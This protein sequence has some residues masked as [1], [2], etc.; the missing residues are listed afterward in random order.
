MIRKNNNYPIKKELLSNK[1]KALPL[2]KNGSKYSPYQSLK[3]SIH[4]HTSL[5]LPFTNRPELKKLDFSEKTPLNQ[6][7]LHIACIE[8]NKE[9]IN[10]ILDV[11]L[12]NGKLNFDLQDTPNKWSPIYYIIDSCDNGQPDLC[13]LLIK[14]NA[15]INISDDKGVTPLHLAAFKGQDD[16]V[17]YFLKQKAKTYRYL[18]LRY[19]INPG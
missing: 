4:I 14:N 9:A 8:S 16:N 2:I 7:I 15:N 1:W 19:L 5:L 11:D 6:N 3:W 17:E 10:L 12:I 18:W 13:E